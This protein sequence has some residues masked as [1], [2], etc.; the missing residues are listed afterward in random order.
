MA[1]PRAALSPPPRAATS[2]VSSFMPCTHAY[3]LGPVGWGKIQS[4]DG[5]E[6]LLRGRLI[7]TPV[8]RLAPFEVQPAPVRSVVVRFLEFRQREIGAVLLHECFAP[9]LQR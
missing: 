6:L 8:Q 2:W 7:A 4:R 1:I 5:C 9:H 3:E